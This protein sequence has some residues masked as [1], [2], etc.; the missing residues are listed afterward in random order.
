[1]NSLSSSRKARLLLAVVVFLIVFLSARQASASGNLTISVNSPQESIPNTEAV[2][3]FTVSESAT[4]SI[5]VDNLPVFQ[6]VSA[7]GGVPVARALN[8][9]EGVHRWKASCAGVGANPLVG[10]T[11]TTVFNVDL[12]APQMVLDSPSGFLNRSAVVFKFTA[13]DALSRVLDC[14]LTLNN[15]VVYSGVFYGGVS[16]AYTLRGVSDGVWFWGLA[17]WDRAGNVGKSA[18]ASFTL[19]SAPP[20][21]VLEAPL[22]D[23]ILADSIVKFNFT[24]RDAL[25]SVAVCDLF[26]N[27]NLK[28]TLSVNLA[29]G[30]RR[31]SFAVEGLEDG[32]YL[33]GVSCRDGVLNLGESVLRNF[34]LDRTPPRVVLDEPSD[35][36]IFKY[37]STV[38][39]SFTAADDRSVVLNCSILVFNLSSAG[40][41]S[42]VPYEVI[43]AEA[44]SGVSAERRLTIL[45]SADYVWYVRCLD[46]AGNA[47][48][49][50]SRLFKIS[51]KQKFVA[52][53]NKSTDD[54]HLL[55]PPAP[56]FQI[57]GYIYHDWCS[58]N[59]T[60]ANSSVNISGND[61]G[62]LWNGT[63]GSNGLYDTGS[64]LTVYRG[65]IITVNAT[66]PNSMWFGS[67]TGVV[68]QSGKT[69]RIDVCL[70]IPEYPEE[71]IIIPIASVMVASVLSI[72]RGRRVIARKK[73][74]S[75]V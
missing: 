62:F 38:G 67:N 28:E 7:L 52:R 45:D 64:T 66:D 43:N 68:P 75:P 17:C 74:S 16:S 11:E 8:L 53:T 56:N 21:V 54:V 24:V 3:N 1:M 49:S 50:G 6:N 35:K 5:A 12:T 46:A 36:T 72:R 34:T 60:Q 37:S 29:S 18:Y 33:W 25:S 31:A 48:A 63:A 15:S 47:G 57:W 51:V 44:Y 23:Q 26:L 20:E 39:F 42:E 59:V 61:S 10:E 13:S 58:I 2:F 41:E 22:Q 14:N 9:T 65:E 30:V 55:S 69:M 73:T 27:Q 40:A 71:R 19:D 32:V 4:C 70:V